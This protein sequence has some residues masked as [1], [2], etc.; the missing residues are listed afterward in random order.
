M[1]IKLSRVEKTLFA[2]VA[3]LAPAL[4]IAWLFSW[5]TGGVGYVASVLAAGVWIWRPQ[6]RDP[7]GRFTT[8]LLL[9]GMLLPLISGCRGAAVLPEPTAPG[10]ITHQKDTQRWQFVPTAPVAM[11]VPLHAAT[12]ARALVLVIPTTAQPVTVEQTSQQTRIVQPENPAAGATLAIGNEQTTATVPPAYKPAAPARLPGAD[13]PTEKALGGLV[14]VGGGLI[15]LGVA[16]MALRFLPWTA[17]LGAV[18]PIGI[19]VL[20]ALAGGLLVAFATVLAAAPW[21]VIGLCIAAVVL[22][23]FL[24]AM[25]DNLLKLSKPK[26]A[27]TSPVA[28][29]T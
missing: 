19:S 1:K 8:K 12:D 15:L 20:I 10:T 11:S 6:G 14:W 3:L 27:P 28:I 16:G 29:T 21:W 2:G 9:L 24:V 7:R 4:V 25:R 18:V 5:T 13:T 17:G 26:P 22:V 23:G